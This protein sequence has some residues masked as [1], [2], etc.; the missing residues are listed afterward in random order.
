MAFCGYAPQVLVM[1]EDVKNSQILPSCLIVSNIGAIIFACFFLFSYKGFAINKECYQKVI[2]Y[3]VHFAYIILEH[4]LFRYVLAPDRANW[5]TAITVSYVI[6]F[7]ESTTNAWLIW[8]H[9]VILKSHNDSQCNVCLHQFNN[10][11]IPRILIQCGHTICEECV[12]KVMKHQI[13]ACP[14]CRKLSFVPH[15]SA[16]GLPKN[17]ALL[18]LMQER[19]Y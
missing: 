4:T 18:G 7:T 12:E 11:V 9:G 19:R 6:C 1:F 8:R 13:V 10:I 14:F 15:G 3:A 17:F 2:I 16:T 5:I